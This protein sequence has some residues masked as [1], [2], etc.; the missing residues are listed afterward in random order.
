MHVDIAIAMSERVDGLRRR[1]AEI[2]RE[3]MRRGGRE[4][5]R[6]R[7]RRGRGWCGGLCV[8]TP[9]CQHRPRDIHGI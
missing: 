4:R 6:G 9:S 3:T 5:R 8:V 7:Q 1:G 2:G